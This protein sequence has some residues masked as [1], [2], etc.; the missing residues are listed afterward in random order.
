MSRQIGQRNLDFLDGYLFRVMVDVL[1]S[2]GAGAG[3]YNYYEARIKSGR[4]ALSDYDRMLFDYAL[5]HLDP[6]RRRIVHAGIGIGTLTSA[7]AVA[8]YQVA[9]IE[10]DGQRFR[11]ASRIRDTLVDAWPDVAERY[12]LFSGG[13]PAVIESTPW[14]ASGSV[15]VFTNCG[16]GWSEELT[17]SII[18]AMTR[19]GDT[20]LDARLFGRV[21]EA[22]TERQE[23]ISRI[24]GH[25]LTATPI[26]EST[27]STFYFH[28]RP[29]AAP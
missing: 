3:L 17:T 4:C 28:I 23:L 29:A 19:F 2:D 24:E 12:E 1:S 10:Q 21:R 6:K 15:L 18:T 5:T 20:I 14:T 16:A 27:P 7:L 13:F 9:G 8:G 11:V 22:P 26:T 25:G